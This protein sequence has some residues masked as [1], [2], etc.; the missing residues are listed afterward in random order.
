MKKATDNKN[1]VETVR[2]FV[3]GLGLKFGG[4]VIKNILPKDPF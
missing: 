3:S 2:N 1:F 4:I